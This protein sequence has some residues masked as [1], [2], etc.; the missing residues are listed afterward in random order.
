[1][2]KIIKFITSVV[3]VSLIGIFSQTEAYE[4]KKS[5]VYPKIITPNGDGYNDRFFIKYSNPYDNELEAKIYDL[6][7]CEIAGLPKSEVEDY[8]YWDGKDSKGNVV[9][10]GAYIFQ[11]RG[12]GQTFNG[13]IIVAR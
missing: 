13:V 7:G 3:C 4:I 1:M 2:N 8:F 11:V 9:E 12:E 5:E 10:S 6:S